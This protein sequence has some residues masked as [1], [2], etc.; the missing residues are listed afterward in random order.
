M[1]PQTGECLKSARMTKGIAVNRE[2]VI[3]L[4]DGRTVLDWEQGLGVDLLNG[5]FFEYPHESFSHPVQ[6][7]DLETLKKAGRVISYDSRF[8][9]LHSLPEIPKKNQT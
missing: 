1:R 2:L 5:E 8:V 9:Y 4:R 6:D 7:D 3:V